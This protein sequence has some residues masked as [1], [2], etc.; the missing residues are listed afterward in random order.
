VDDDMLMESIDDSDGENMMDV[1]LLLALVF[2][3]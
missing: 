2:V 3:V 1:G